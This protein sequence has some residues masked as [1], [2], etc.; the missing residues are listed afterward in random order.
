MQ[1]EMRDTRAEILVWLPSPMGDAILCTPA[2]RAISQ[3]FKSCRIWLLAEPVVREVLSPSNF[4][5][6]WLTPRCKNPFSIAK[7]LKKHKFTHAVLFKNSFA[8]ALTVFL[9][10]IPSRI[11]YAR[12][13]R[14][15]LLTEKLYP[16]KLSTGKFKPLSMIDY[17][18][19]IA[20]RLGAQ[21]VSRS[22]ELLVEPKCDYNLKTKLPE[23]DKASGPVVIL[24]PGGAFGPSKCWPSERFAQTADWLIA[25]YNAAVVVSVSPDPSE[26]KIGSE[27]CDASRNKLINLSEK[28]INLGELKTLFSRASLVI[29][30]DTGPRHIAIALQRKVVT[31]FGPN[32]PTW[33]ETNYE[34]EIQI[35]GNV[36]CA[37][38]TKPLC[39]KNQ[40]LCMQAITV[41][42]VCNAAKQLFSNNRKQA[43]VYARQKF[44]EASDSF[45][46]DPD[47]EESFS[48]LGL[49]SVDAV[50]SFNAAKNLVKNNLAAYRARLQF[51]INSPLTTLEICTEGS[52]IPREDLLLTGLTTLFLKR[53]EK[54]PILVQVKNWLTHRG[55]K[56]CSFIEF[57]QANSLTEAGINTP[58][59]VSFGQQWGP[60]FEKRSFIITEKIPNAESLERRLPSFFC[61]PARC[62]NLRLRRNFISQLASFVKKFHET[63][64]RHRDL[65]FSHIFYSDSGDFYLIDLARAFRPTILRRR[66]QVKD[67]AQLYYSA[68]AKYFSN[69]DRL[70]FYLCYVGRNKLV[71]GDKNFIRKILH[72]ANRMARHD[73]K[74]NK[75]APFMSR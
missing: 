46:I 12:Q 69:T 20:S 2:L 41:E 59:I 56:S 48:K 36:P 39:K 21:A 55:F 10:G 34:S 24:V 45:S 37:P 58:K 1:Y 17:Y 40:H 53:Y 29:T 28:N 70:R 22:L 66:F 27:I 42:M 13:G 35:V 32:D 44:V 26:K 64:Y 52:S 73:A 60:L 14:G 38:C 68:P 11:G 61:G 49:T 16:S 75:F 57:E 25:N 7:L 62:E 54:P 4:N 43:I 18:L 72:R 50:F 30:N 71:N 5:N 9:A 15:F 63:G 74:H 65:Y 51:E 31:L 23:L 8:S 19:D 6:E 33:T 3:H 47:Y 67:I